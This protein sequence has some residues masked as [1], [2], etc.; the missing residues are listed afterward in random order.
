MVREKEELEKIRVENNVERTEIL[1]NTDEIVKRTINDFRNI[2]QQLDNCTDSTGPSVFFNTPIWK[3][4]VALKN[5]GIKLRFITEITKDNI[6]YCKELMKIA[7]L[8]HLDGVKGNFG[9]IDGKDYGGSASVKEGQP[10]VELIRSNV[11]TFVDQQ[12]FF[13]ETLWSKATPAEQKI[14]EIEEGIEYIKTTVLENKQEIYDHF[15]KTIES[16]VERYVCSSIGGM[17]MVYN[18]FF[19]LYKNIID[20]QK[21]GEGNGIKW[22]T[23]IDSNKNS[24]EIVRAFLHEGIQIKHIK[25]LPPMNFSVDS[26]SIQATIENMDK[27]KL[28]NRLLVSNERAYVNH[29]IL[30]F[31]ELWNNYGIDAIERIKDVEEGIEYDTEI[32]RNADHALKIYLDVIKSTKNEIY[33]I[34]PTPRAFIHQLKAIYLAIQIS[35]ERKAKIRILTPYNETVKE[36]I[37]N[38]FEVE[39]E[40]EENIKYCRDYFSNIDIEIK[41]IEK[42]SQTKATILV[43]DS[44]QSMVIELK[45]DTK[46]SFTQAIGLYTYS[47]SKASV[48]SYVAI[49]ENLWKQ[50]ELYQELKESNEKLKINDKI[51]N[52]FIH[53]A[54]HELLN[55]IQ[56]ILGLSEIAKNRTI[57]KEQKKFLEIINKNAKKIK[58]LSENILDITKIE[59]NSFTLNKE[60]FDIVELLLNI[61]DEYKINSNLENKTLATI[62]LIKHNNQLANIITNYHN[63]GNDDFIIYADKI[64]INQVI[65]NLINNAM[66]FSS[67]SPITIIAEKKYDNI[68]KKEELVISVKDTGIGIDDKIFPKLFSKFATMSTKEGTGL[69]LYICKNI[70]EAHGGKIW[71]NNNDEDGKGATFSFSLPLFNN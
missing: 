68:S 67:N 63:H 6:K 13:F 33:F 41:Y 11:K 2:K 60:E 65:T 22:L 47:T 40:K 38:L 3:E 27:G 28:M 9:I 46:D 12:Q 30:F 31:Q 16:S 10:P 17:Q 64:R 62:L 56:P 32:I 1:Y 50:S 23:Y 26:K 35:R 36:W 70:I 58:K 49:F 52:E 18:N 48:L 4:F 14:K 44:K 19:N 59:S 34:F 43:V 25:N 51:L 66:K 37:K 61:K 57:D 71:A 42:M 54:A 69:G 29:F 24:I 55:P 15:I 21:K 45:D 5:R 7:N 39:K 20:R 8:R 53:T